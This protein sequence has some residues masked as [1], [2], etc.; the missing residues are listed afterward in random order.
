MEKNPLNHT[1]LKRLDAAKV[2]E[3]NLQDVFCFLRNNAFECWQCGS[4]EAIDNLAG[5]IKVLE[6]KMR[7]WK[8]VVVFKDK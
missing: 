8:E 4:G 6:D 3:M 2:D 7:Q 5:E 1:I